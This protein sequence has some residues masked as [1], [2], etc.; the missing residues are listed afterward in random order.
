MEGVTVRKDWIAI[1][2]AAAMCCGCAGS[3]GG[4]PA[5]S[6]AAVNAGGGPTVAAQGN[7][8]P[9]QPASWTDRLQAAVIAPFQAGQQVPPPSPPDSISL[10]AGTGAVTPELFVSM[11]GMCERA[12]DIAQARHIYGQAL[13]LAPQHTGAMLG[14]ARLEDRQGQLDDALGWYQ[15]AAYANPQDA[16]V[17]NDYGLC[18][19]RAGRFQEA[20]SPLG[21]AVRLDPAKQLYRNNIA[22]VL[23][24]L[25]RPAEAAQHLSAVLDPATVN[26]NMAVLLLEQNRIDEAARCLDLAVSMNPEMTEASDLLAQMTAEPDDTM[27][28]EDGPAIGSDVERVARRSGA[29]VDVNSAVAEA[30]RDSQPWPPAASGAAVR[31]AGESTSVNHFDEPLLLP[32]VE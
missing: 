30:V 31:P 17:A 13:R 18:L 8:G 6:M 32:A 22:K 21:Q 3:T 25:D 11:G 19:A 12:G 16:I 1:W 2:A 23:V 9:V 28:A 14:M 10:S 29:G 20:L 15:Q 5:G 27:L 4:A 26:Y 7:Y 24:A